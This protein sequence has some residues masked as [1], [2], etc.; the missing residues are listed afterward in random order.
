MFGPITVSPKNEARRE[1]VVQS[2]AGQKARRAELEGAI[3]DIPAVGGGSGSM[4]AAERA[5][6]LL[7]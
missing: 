4:A 7:D 5:L 6:A 2:A 1:R 3:G